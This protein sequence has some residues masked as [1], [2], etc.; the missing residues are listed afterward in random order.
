MKKLTVCLMLAAFAMVSTLQAG[1]KNAK[2][3]AACS[4][5]AKASCSASAKTASCGEKTACCAKTA[6]KA[7]HAK[8][9]A[10]LLARL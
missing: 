10:T 6:A 3:Q 4:D 7:R 8:R 1:E 5:S 9:G 2:S